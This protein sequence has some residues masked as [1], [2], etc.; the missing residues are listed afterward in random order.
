MVVCDK[1]SGAEAANDEEFRNEPENDSDEDEEDEELELEDEEES[2][3]EFEALAGVWRFQKGLSCVRSKDVVPVSL[4]LELEE[5][6][7]ENCGMIVLSVFVGRGFVRTLK[8]RT[9]AAL[10]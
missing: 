6:A 4:R 5:T 1:D 7:V 2:E 10:T 9:V 3:A 8:W